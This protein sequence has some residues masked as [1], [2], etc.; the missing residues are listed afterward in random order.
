MPATGRPAGAR[1]L[2][3]PGMLPCAWELPAAVGLKLQRSGAAPPPHPTPLRSSCSLTEF[4]TTTSR[5]G[6]SASHTLI[7]SWTLPSAK[8][9]SSWRWVRLCTWAKALTVV[10]F[11]EGWG[12]ARLTAT[13]L[14][15]VSAQGAAFNA[16]DPPLPPLPLPNPPGPP[17]T[18]PSPFQPPSNTH[19][20]TLRCRH[21]RMLT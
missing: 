21:R 17:D 5:T 10:G 13:A 9:C 15:R 4:G 20:W 19:A 12:G 3:D 16:R 2:R 8:S 11:A 14:A 7:S 1:L 18:P 6:R